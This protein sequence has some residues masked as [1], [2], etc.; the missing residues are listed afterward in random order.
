MRIQC[1]FILLA[2]LAIVV[3]VGLA[4]WVLRPR[5]PVYHGKRLSQWLDEYNRAGGM[6]KT[7]PISD[8]IRAMGTN[9]LPFLLAHIKHTESP[10]KGKFFSLI[11]K[12]HWVK[13]PF[14]GADPYLETSILALSALGSNAAPICPDLLKVAENPD[15]SWRGTMSLLAIGPASVPTLAK[16]CQSTNSH[17]RTEAVLMMAMQKAMPAP[18]FSWGYSKAPVNG[19]LMFMV[20]YA[21][22]DEDVQEMINLLANPDSAIR[23]ASA[24]AIG[25]YTRPPYTRVAHSAVGPLTELLKEADPVLRESA[26]ETLKKIDPEAAA[27]AGVK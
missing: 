26:A 27:K 19:Q 6:D 24:E 18:W 3:V 1:K 13:L 14:Y 22:S 4:S 7:G 5:E 16:A 10:L 11:G 15:S 23:R 17:L 12:Q 8:A 20:G 25:L 2:V 9:T 21:V